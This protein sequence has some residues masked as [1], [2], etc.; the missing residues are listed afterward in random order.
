[1]LI[2]K[3]CLYNNIKKKNGPAMTENMRCEWSFAHEAQKSTLESGTSVS[4][5]NFSRL[6]ERADR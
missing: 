5:A 6:L 4:Q 2:V 3:L 1:M